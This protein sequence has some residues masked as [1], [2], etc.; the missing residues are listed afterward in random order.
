MSDFDHS[1][2]MQSIAAPAFS[3]DRLAIVSRPIPVPQRGEILVRVKAA[4]LN[5]RDLAVLSGSYLPDLPL[6]YTPGSDA[7]GVVQAVGA[8][9]TRFAVGDRVIPC[10]IQGWHDGALTLEQ[11][12]ER[13][14]GGPLPGVLQEFIVVPAEDAVSVPE[15]LSDAE[16]ST[17]PI[18][19]LTAWSCLL[20]G[21]IKAGDNVL[22]Q[23][24]GGVALFALQLA[25]AAGARVIA[26]TSDAAKAEL[27]RRLGADTVINY[28]ETPAWAP[29]VRAAT[30]GRGVEIVV[31]TAG[32]SLPQ[33]LAAVAFG[34]FVGVIGFVG[35]YET[36]LNIRQLIGPMV[37]LQGIVVGSRARL[38]ALIRAMSLHQIKPV[39]DSSFTLADTAAAFRRLASGAHTGKIVITL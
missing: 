20:E 9:V 12:F 25:G 19:G 13:T 16:A 21:G 30:G 1:A 37:R 10:Y 11:R 33:S 39:I 5:Y 14:L 28:R 26:L 17:L 3:V 38:E 27:L 6:P 7:C 22:V 36:A 32:S 2:L 18:A 23:G 15:Y 31:E 34:G 8:G 35:G 4:S 29:A 24:T